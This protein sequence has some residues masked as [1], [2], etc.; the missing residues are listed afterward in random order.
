VIAIDTSG[1]ESAPATI[2]V[3]TDTDSS[4]PD[5]PGNLAAEEFVTSIKLTWSVPFDN[6][7]VTSYQVSRD[8]NPIA[9]VTGTSYDDTGLDPNT[10]FS[11]QVRA[12]DARLNA[13]A[14]AGIGA[15]TDP[16][17]VAPTTPGDLTGTPDMNSIQLSWLASTDPVGLG[18][19]RYRISRN[20]NVVGSVSGLTFTDT[21]LENGI[22]YHY[23][24]VAIDEADNVSLPASLSL[25]TLSDSEDPTPPGDLAAEA[26]YTVIHLS[27]TAATDNVGV[28]GYEIRRSG[29]ET[30]LATVTTLGYSVEG[31]ASGTSYSFEVRAKDAANRLSTAATVTKT[32]LGFDDWLGEHDLTGE[33]TADSDGGG[34][35]NFA[36]FRL[37]MDPSDP[38]DDLTFRLACTVGPA[39]I[40]IVCPELKPVGHYYLHASS[41]LADIKTV[42]NRVLALTPEDIEA[43]SPEQR[44]HYVVEVPVNG[45]RKFVVLIFEPLPE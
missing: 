3:T 33:E 17:L 34:L 13:S 35:D 22:E 18:V 16:D 30:P 20:G 1:V 24:V 26:D 31:L 27:W 37:G 25:E 2:S 28:V 15:S 9:T 36:E 41:S 32:T 6:I 12:L 7:G 40:Q 5:A 29:E 8:G 23:Q 4:P 42:E 19:D 14:P 45:E 43:M 11:Y 44:E 10:A 39:A 38:S 21:G